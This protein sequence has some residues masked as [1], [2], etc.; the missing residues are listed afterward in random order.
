MCDAHD[1]L[2]FG[3]D[4]LL[5]PRHLFYT[6]LSSPLLGAVEV[7]VEKKPSAEYKH[8]YYRTRYACENA[9]S[10]NGKGRVDFKHS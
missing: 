4:R 9:L 7:G 6:G 1:L 10:L 8:C 3:I 5:L 2:F